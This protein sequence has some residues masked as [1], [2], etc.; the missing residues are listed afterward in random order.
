M[1]ALS[2]SEI[3]DLTGGAIGTFDTACPQC[4]PERRSAVNRRRK[5]LR[6]WSEEPGFASF[7]CARCGL[8]GY[9][10]EDGA[11][12]IDP[13]RLARLKAEAAKHKAEDDA[14]RTERALALWQTA[15]HP[16]GSPVETYLARRGLILPDDAAGEAIRYHSAC[17]FA[18]KRVPTMLA[19]VRDVMTDAPKAIHR[20]VLS[21]DGRKVEIDG[22]NR[23]A[24]GPIAGGAVKLTPDADVTMAV[25]IGE[26]IETTL[27][28]RLA[29]EFGPSPV[30][31]LLSAGG[32]E[33][34]LVLAGIESLWIAVDHD[35]AGIRAARTCAGRW[36][37]AG[38]EV[39]LITPSAPDADLNDIAGAA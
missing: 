1:R 3:L 11:K 26:G 16:R 24:L 10:R 28:L 20:T 15:R 6:I 17:P 13:Q 27:S 31:A 38:R 29:P 32:I 37:A 2:F 7:S 19:L 39:F 12:R 35:P 25:G 4:G 8:Q 34:F 22:K 21:L 33:G 18:G 36:Q 23:L 5:V 9:A 14:E 30:W